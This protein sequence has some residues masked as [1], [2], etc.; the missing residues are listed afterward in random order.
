MKQQVLWSRGG[1]VLIL[2]LILISALSFQA[3]PLAEAS[4]G[5]TRPTEKVRLALNWKPEP[6]FGGFYA[7]RFA[8]LDKKNGIEF[9]LIPG[10]SGTPVVQMVASGQFDFGIASADE[11]LV[12]RGR[13]SDG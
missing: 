8:D 12:S 2:V 11:V 9:E 4:K 3:M 5:A 6:Q 1:F 13:G 7:A 10:G